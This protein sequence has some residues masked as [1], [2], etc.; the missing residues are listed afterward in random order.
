MEREMI[1]D[2]VAEAMQEQMRD[3][4][5]ERERHYQD[6]EFITS[7]RIWSDTCKSTIL[8][9]VVKGLVL[10]ALGLLLMGTILWGRTNLK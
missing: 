6:H 1:K 9:T 10:G 5:I 4:Y 7:I 3:F 2:A 8:T